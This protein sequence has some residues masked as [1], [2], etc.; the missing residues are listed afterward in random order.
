MVR[1]ALAVPAG[2]YRRLLL[3]DFLKLAGHQ[4]AIL[5][6]FTPGLLFGCL[7]GV[8]KS[9]QVLFKLYISSC[10]TDFDNSELASLVLQGLP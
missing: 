6:L 5:D 8:S 4:T 2:C 3:Q 10:G 1:A 7:K 9:V